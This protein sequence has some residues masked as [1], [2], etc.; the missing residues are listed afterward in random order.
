M[1]TTN[2]LPYDIARSVLQKISCTLS[3]V[4]SLMI[5]LSIYHGKANSNKTQQ[6]F[7]LGI[8]CS[9]FITSVTWIFSDLLM[10]PIGNIQSCNAQGFLVQFGVSSGMIYMV[11]LQLQYVLAI[12]YGWSE[13]DL[14][15]LEI[16]LWTPLLYSFGTA[17]AALVMD[18]YNPATWNCWIA[19]YPSDCT[20]T[21]AINKG[22]SDLEKTDCIRGNYATIYQWAFFYGPLWVSITLCIVA[23][24]LVA[25]SVKSTERKTARKSSSTMSRLDS[26]VDDFSGSEYR[27]T[28]DVSERQEQDQPT[29]LHGGTTVRTSSIIL[30]TTNKVFQSQKNSP[31]L[32]LT[33]RV[34]TQCILYSTGFLVIWSFPTAFRF[35][36]LMGWTIHPI[37]SVFAGFF[38]GCQGVWNAVIYFRPKYNKVEKR[39]WWEK[40]W[41]LLK[42]NLFVCKCSNKEDHQNDQMA[43]IQV[44]QEMYFYDF[45]SHKF[46]Y[47]YRKVLSMYINFYFFLWLC[48]SSFPLE[49]LAFQPT[50]WWQTK[51]HFFWEKP[52]AMRKHEIIKSTI[53]VW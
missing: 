17:I 8:S 47:V 10:P 53:L 7:L 30:Q 6:R 43:P 40:V 39:H 33:S 27:G 1:A 18:L 21:Y 23:M 20:Y 49:K 52:D 9:D 5:F 41:V 50:F 22:Y 12:K 2:N 11:A 14:K 28:I 45:Y 31:S 3:A 24:S 19:P 36:G 51:T 48:W 15:R 38:I 29:G 4:C 26:N 46:W 13:K 37:W 34:R 42:T 16:L 35:A 25:R 44:W 32:A